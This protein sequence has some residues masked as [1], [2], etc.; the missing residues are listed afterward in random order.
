MLRLTRIN[1]LAIIPD[2][3]SYQ[4]M[5]IKAKDYITWGEIDQETLTK[6]IDKRGMLPG[7]VAVTEDYLKE[8]TDYNSVEE[9]SQALLEEEIKLEDAGLKPIFRLHPPRK[10]F[11]GTRRA[12][13]EKGSLGYRGGD[14]NQLI[15]RMM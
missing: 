7:R 2:T 1:H 15:D 5:L 10:G 4:G 8:N 11:K 14:I 9:L 13:T 6:L 12:Y 3:P